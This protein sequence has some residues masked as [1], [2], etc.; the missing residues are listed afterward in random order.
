MSPSPYSRSQVI[1]IIEQEAQRSGIPHDDFL[2]FAAI[3]TGGRFDPTVS[4]GANGAK[5]LFQFEP[6]PASH[7]GIAGQE[8]DAVANTHAAA[9]MYLDNRRVVETHHARDGRAYLSGKATPDGFDMY[10]THQQ[11]A[12]GYASIQSAIATGHFARTDTRDNLLNNIS[13]RDIQRVTGHSYADVNHMSDRDLATTYRDYWSHKFERLPVPSRQQEAPRTTPTTAPTHAPSAQAAP[14]P[15]PAHAASPAPA[16][17]HGG[18]VLS[19]AYALTAKYEHKVAYGFGQKNPETGKVD[20][21]GWIVTAENASMDE[22]NR[23]A[24]REVFNRR[25]HLQIKADCAADIIRKAEARSG[26]MLEGAAVTRDAL[27]EGMVIGECNGA[28]FAKGRYHD[29]DHITMVVRD[30]TSGELM[31]SQSSSHQGVHLTPVDEYLKFKQSHHVALYA[32]DPLSKARDL[33]QDRQQ[34]QGRT[35]PH[36]ASHAPS[37]GA[38][39]P[40]LREGARGEDVAQLQA[41]LR[42]MGYVDAHGRPLAVDHRFGPDTRAAVQAYQRDHHLHPDGDVGPET[43]QSMSKSQAQHASPRLDH[44]GHPDHALFSQARDGVH[45]LDTQHGRAPD[46]RSD[47]M[48]GSVAVAAKQAG[49]GRI[50]QVMLSDDRVRLYA[51]QGDLHSPFKQVAHVEAAQAAQTSLQQSSDAMLAINPARSPESPAQAQQ[52]TAPAPSQDAPDG[53]TR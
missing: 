33:I 35:E 44:P 43:R 41:A 47:N 10:V 34:T 2:K 28:K 4:R 32:T 12:A 24:G 36:V 38:V 16:G 39:A 6:G 21:S 14:T 37:Q 51:V 25:D 50:D 29:I 31:I 20:C 1:G 52:R 8:L 7:Y 19:D 42:Q 13:D 15:T 18:I 45:R 23:K 30:P 49:M 5:G 27:K 26:V 53:M 22:I 9:R 40:V 3:E 48:A 46:Q 11:G 17:G